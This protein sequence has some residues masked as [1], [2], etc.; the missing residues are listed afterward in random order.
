MPEESRPPMTLAQFE[1]QERE[2]LAAAKTG[3]LK[4][5]CDACGEALVDS[6]PGMALMTAPPKIRVHCS[7]CGW[8]GFAPAS[9]RKL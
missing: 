8:S 9:V 7:G 4:V 5:A 2:R 3:R 1:A 6:D